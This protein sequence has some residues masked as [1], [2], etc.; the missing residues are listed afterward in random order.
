[1]MKDRYTDRIE[2]RDSGTSIAEWLSFADTC[3]DDSFGVVCKITPDDALMLLNSEDR[4][5]NRKIVQSVV[6]QY[7]KFMEQGLWEMN[8]VPLLFTRQNGICSFFDGQHRLESIRTTGITQLVFCAFNLNERC[9]MTIDKHRKRTLSDSARM[10]GLMMRGEDDA[11]VRLLWDFVYNKREIASYRTNMRLIANQSLENERLEYFINH[12]EVSGS[13]KLIHNYHGSNKIS[14]PRSAISALHFYF[15]HYFGDAGRASEFVDLVY[16][17]DG[18]TSDSPAFHLRNFLIQDYPKI[19]QYSPR[20]GNTIVFCWNEFMAHRLMNKRLRLEIQL[21]KHLLNIS[22]SRGSDGERKPATHVPLL[23]PKKGTT[24]TYCMETERSEYEDL[25]SI[26]KPET[27]KHIQEQNP[28]HIGRLYLP[29]ALLR[30]R[31]SVSYLK[32]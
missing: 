5:P 24:S 9:I 29:M 32:D 22:P 1:M 13:V 23:L 2:G 14:G 15:T 3:P 4:V 11:A 17:G 7:S 28:R 20:V 19:N 16:K 8:F 30:H 12:P 27:D 25:L 26:N 6:S 21:E 18:L 31:R 10:L